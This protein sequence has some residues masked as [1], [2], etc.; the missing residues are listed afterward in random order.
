MRMT[1]TL[2]RCKT[3]IAC[4][5]SVKECAL[6]G[7]RDAAFPITRRSFPKTPFQSTPLWP[8]RPHPWLS[9]PMRRS[10]GLDSGSLNRLLIKFMNL[11][12]RI[13]RKKTSDGPLD[14]FD[15]VLV[16]LTIDGAQCLFIL[17]ACDG[18][19]NRMGDGSI[20]CTDN[21]MFV[22]R[23]SELLFSQFLASVNPAMLAR[24]GTY[25]IPNPAG[26]K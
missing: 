19:V 23:S 4:S 1:P 18:T 13:F 8:K 22:G 12:S 10:F 11:L 16:V 9:A 21:N 24:K 25:D 14:R 20:G 7:H 26:K 2:R 6:L 17:L 15:K 3:F 5:K